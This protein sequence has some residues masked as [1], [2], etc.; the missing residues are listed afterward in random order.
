MSHTPILAFC[1][2]SRPLLP[3]GTGNV[4]ALQHV[5]RK[6]LRGTRKMSRRPQG[7]HRRSSVALGVRSGAGTDKDG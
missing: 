3:F 7:G 2:R 1:L 6:V 4:A 5:A